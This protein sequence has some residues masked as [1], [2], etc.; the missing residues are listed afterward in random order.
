MGQVY[1]DMG[2]LSSVEV[3]ESSAS[4]LIAQYSGQTGPKTKAVLE[5]ALGKVLLVDE[6][7]RLSGSSFGKEALDELV[8]L[9]TKPKFMGKIVVILA[10]YD[11][12]INELVAINPGLSSRFPEEIIFQNMSPRH[13]LQILERNLKQKEIETPALNDTKSPDYNNMVGLLE[14]LASTPNWGNARDIQ[15]LA[16]T[17]IGSVYKSS[18]MTAGPLSISS[19][20][21][22]SCTRNMLSERQS[23]AA[24]LSPSSLPALLQQPTQSLNHSPSPRHAVSTMSTTKQT[25]PNL[26]KSESPDAQNTE[27][28]DPGVSDQIW[29]QLQADKEAVED[30]Q[31]IA[32]QQLQKQAEE[33]ARAKALEA[34]K[35]AQLARLARQ[36]AQD[37]AEMNELKRRREEARL[38]EQMAR[39]AREKLL[40]ELERVRAEQQK[41]RQQEAK[42]QQKL[43]EMGVCPVGFR[44]IKQ[45]GGYRCAGGSH[46]VGDGEL[47]M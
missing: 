42:A 15:T 17:M 33:L 46:W 44:W 47:G 13:C 34:E 8:D 26:D 14:K 29:N 22:L 10:G 20:D 2:F 27:N 9:L 23:R 18:S 6:S 41:Q 24:N 12:E 37:D 5:K 7:Y 16:K 19:E 3:I 36:K 25:A 1:Y 30:A 40:A 45:S 21:I 28:R 35:T 11:K 38:Q 31:K 32:E 43:R 4:E 39:V